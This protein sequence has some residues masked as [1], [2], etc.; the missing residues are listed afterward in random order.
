MPS[1]PK[2][3]HARPQASRAEL[4]AAYDARRG[5]A[6]KRGYVGQ[7]DLASAVF[8]RKHPLCLGCEAVGRVVATEVTDHVEPHRGDMAKFW[9]GELWQPACRWHHDVVKQ[10]LEALFDRGEILVADLWLDSAIARRLTLAELG[11]QGGGSLS[12]A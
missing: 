6:R 2:T 10:K 7:W 5:S 12:Q 8:K 3:F 1:R 9:N 4:N 11:G